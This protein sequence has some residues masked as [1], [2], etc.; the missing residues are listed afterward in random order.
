MSLDRAIIPFPE[1]S[2]IRRLKPKTLIF[3]IKLLY[4]SG[5][6]LTSFYLIILFIVQPLLTL[7]YDRRLNLISHIFDNLR[8]M[9]YFKITGIL[10][11]E[12]PTIGV[13]YG[14]KLYS[15]ANIQ[16]EK[17]RDRTVIDNNGDTEKLDDKLIKLRN[18]LLK[19]NIMDYKT[20]R[21]ENNSNYVGK[22]EIISYTPSEI[23]PLFFQLKQLYNYLDLI[24][25]DIISRNSS[26]GYS[27]FKKNP[28]I[29][30]SNNNRQ[31]NNNNNNNNNTSS[32]VVVELKKELK[33]IRKEIMKNYL[34]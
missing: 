3:V 14:N 10:K 16:T 11:G 7:Q 8:N 23:S 5:I 27:F 13:K 30:S 15:D 24:S 28:N 6:L 20:D 19:I 25:D 4:S 17:T 22:S 18:V 33:N 29:V 31:N 2:D 9:I 21:N 12:V 34:N 32:N 1:D 26:K